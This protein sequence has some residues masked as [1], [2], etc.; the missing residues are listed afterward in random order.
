MPGGSGG[1]L[2]RVIKDTPIAVLDFET[3]GLSPGYDQ[4][5]R[6]RWCELTPA[7]VHDWCSTRW[8]IQIAGWPPPRFTASG[9]E[10]WPTPLGWK[11]LAGGLLRALSDSVVVA[12]N[13]YFDLRFLRFELDRLG[14]SGRCPTSARCT[15]V[16]GRA[17]GR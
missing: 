3:T 8:S 15:R 10:M 7:P 2:H 1:V 11:E 17:H 6:F 16:P 5:S 12:H 13:V 14:C 4:F 9:I